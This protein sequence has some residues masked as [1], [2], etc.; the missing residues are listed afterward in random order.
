VLV[1][2]PRASCFLAALAIAMA[3]VSCISEARQGSSN[4]KYVDRPKGEDRAQKSGKS[5]VALSRGEASASERAKTDDRGR[6]S[7]S[8]TSN[9]KQSSAETN[10]FGSAV[11][12]M[13]GH[14]QEQATALRKASFDV[15]TQVIRPTADQSDALERIRSTATEASDALA[16]AC[17]KTIPALLSERLEILSHVLSEIAGSL[18]ALRPVLVS[19]YASLD[20]EQKARLAVSSFL[21]SQPKSDA[22]S[23]N[24]YVFYDRIDPG[25]NAGCG[26]WLT[27]LR[28]W[29][30]REIARGIT[31]SDEQHAAL[32]EV[33][34]ATYR[35]AG[36]LLMSCPAENP[37]TPVGRLD[38]ERDKTRALRNGMDAIQS[39]L[40]SFENTLNVDQKKSF[41]AI[42]NSSPNFRALAP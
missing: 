26:Y 17:P 3:G 37:L 7:A 39:V 21:A 36:D 27:A 20:D 4:I 30:I 1:S 41:D 11:E 25:Q 15:V 35:A 13:I 14:C 29:P 22:D 28:S 31:L 34:A 38:V 6:G 33:A 10:G 2:A 16:A 8:Q 18:K 12:Q 40:A 9:G 42:V 24:S 5:N 23:R 19:F 32:H